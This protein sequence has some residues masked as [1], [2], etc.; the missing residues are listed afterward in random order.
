[1]LIILIIVTALV[2]IDQATKLM[3]TAW[4]EPVG[5]VPI[6]QNV[7]HLTYAKNSGAAFGSLQG[8]RWFFLTLTV[9]AIAVILW[10]LIKYRKNGRLLEIG[11]VLTLAGAIGNM[12][13]RARLGYVVDMID[14]KAINFAIFNLADSC[15]SIGCVL[16]VLYIILSEHKKPKRRHA[17]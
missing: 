3:C 12:I 16:L 7:L 13:D 9:V 15:L 8:G 4:L 1:M 11:L 17:K 10:M 14:F 6:I 5:T 2:A